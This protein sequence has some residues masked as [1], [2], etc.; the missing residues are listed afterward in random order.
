MVE[1]IKKGFFLGMF[2]IISLSFQAQNSL[3]FII[4][5]AE[6]R[7]P[8]S[9]YIYGVNI[10]DFDT[11]SDVGYTTNRFGGNRSTPYNWEN[12]FSNA[13][14]DFMQINDQ[15]HLFVQ[16]LNT[17]VF[18]D[19]PG[20]VYE[21][22]VDSTLAGGVDA[23]LQLPVAG[24]V[25]G[26]EDGVVSCAAPCDRWVPT[27]A[28][29]PGENYQF[30]PDLTDNAVFID[31][32]IVHMID[33]FGTAEEGGIKFYE[34]GN[35]PTLW[36]STHPFIRP[37][38]V[39]IEEMISIQLEYGAMIKRIDPSSQTLGFSAFG[40]FAWEAFLNI[41]E[42]IWRN[43]FDSFLSFYLDQMRQAE[44]EVGQRLIDIVDVHIYPEHMS[45]PSGNRVAFSDENSIEM[46]DARVQS[47]RSLWDPTY[48]EDSWI[49]QVRN[50]P[51]MM[52]RTIKERVEEHYPGTKIAITEW[53]YGPSI[54]QFAIGLATAEVLGIYGR[55]EIY[56]ANHFFDADSFT[57]GG[58]RL[59]TNYNGDGGTYGNINVNASNPDVENVSI[60]S[61]VKEGDN[62]NE[63]HIILINKDQN[64]TLNA[65]V[66]INSVQTYIEGMAYSFTD[67]NEKPVFD[68][69][70]TDINNNS[71]TYEIPA[72]SAMHIVLNSE[73]IVSAIDESI[74]EKSKIQVFPNP[75]SG[76]VNLSE[77]T[78]WEVVNLYGV[79]LI[80]GEGSI[81]N[82]SGMQ[83]GQYFI[84]TESGVFKITKE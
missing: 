45:R 3:N 10:I 38:P 72:F 84:K 48:I 49:T 24:Y 75:T 78:T 82:L 12:N 22:F 47:P 18:G 7:T 61:S 6:D 42:N 59:F 57:E 25:S 51:I 74:S 16:G 76:I 67:A 68:G 43:D 14:S 34:I 31:E 71:F 29:K 1:S 27:F 70:V 32:S 15:W 19:A 40:F 64:N 36:N 46:N 13:G 28:N 9:P 54:D 41:D 65:S 23:I 83:S 21:S 37:T 56:M 5:T 80:S 52:V 8:I 81:I 66:S 77:N 35:E 20:V 26:D 58:F 4:N 33:L 17:N 79:E 62:D 44:E 2:F 60:Y 53:E 50:E 30:P 73:N 11:E 39:G 69:I 63:L 55:E